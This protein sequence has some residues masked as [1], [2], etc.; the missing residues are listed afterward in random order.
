MSSFAL[1][2]ALGLKILALFSVDAVILRSG[3]SDEEIREMWPNQLS[4]TE[5]NALTEQEKKLYSKVYGLTLVV[6][7]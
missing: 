7:L 3:L 2:L 5:R 6:H 4:V 1:A